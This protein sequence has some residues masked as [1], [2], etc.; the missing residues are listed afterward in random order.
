MKD[1]IAIILLLTFLYFVGD[2]AAL[3]RM[4]ASVRNGF[5]SEA[6]P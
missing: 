3:G 4:A 6:T 2:P 1:T 5:N